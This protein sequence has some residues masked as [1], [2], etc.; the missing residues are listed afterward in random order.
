MKRLTEAQEKILMALCDMPEGCWQR[1][2]GLKCE[3]GVIDLNWWQFKWALRRLSAAGL[4]DVQQFRQF[5][6]SCQKLKSYTATPAGRTAARAK[7]E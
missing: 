1:V 5:W 3:P 4:I 7:G 2:D 6:A